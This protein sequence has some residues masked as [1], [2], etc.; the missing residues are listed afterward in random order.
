MTSVEGF[1]IFLELS[2][3]NDQRLATRFW[4]YPGVSVV[5]VTNVKGAC[6]P[7]CCYWYCDGVRVNINGELTSDGAGP[8]SHFLLPWKV[9]SGS[10]Y[11]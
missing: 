7:C 4:K 11:N 8:V 9:K 3:E 10:I 1:E 2:L 6:R 5:L